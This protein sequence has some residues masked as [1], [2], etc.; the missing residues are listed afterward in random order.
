MGGGGNPDREEVLFLTSQLA[1]GMWSFSG[2][3]CSIHSGG[4]GGLSV[5]MMKIITCH[6]S[7]RLS[8]QTFN[9][10]EKQHMFNGLQSHLRL[11]KKTKKKTTTTN[12]E[13]AGGL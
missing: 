3:K 7:F 6:L 13:R 10:Y 2:R 4:E 8:L 11:K 5:F 1:G 12:P 9:Q